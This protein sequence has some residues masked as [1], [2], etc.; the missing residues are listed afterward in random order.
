MKKIFI[1]ISYVMAMVCYSGAFYSFAVTRYNGVGIVCLCF[2]S[3]MLC[4]GSVLTN[5][6]NKK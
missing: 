1:I 5:K 4:F 6:F 2:G 3:A